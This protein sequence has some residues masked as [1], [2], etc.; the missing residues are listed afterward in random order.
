VVAVAVAVAKVPVEQGKNTSAT[1]SGLPVSPVFCI[2]V[3]GG[4][5]KIRDTFEDSGVKWSL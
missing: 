4:K 3:I 1:L 2:A 5:K